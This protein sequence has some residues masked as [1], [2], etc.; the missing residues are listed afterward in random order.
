LIIQKEKEDLEQDQNKMEDLGLFKKNFDIYLDRYLEKKINNISRFTKDSSALS[1]LN[2]L[3]IISLS[4]GKRIRPYLAYLMYKT[5]SKKPNEKIL[6]FLV[7]LEI[8][9]IFC[10]IHDDVMDKSDLR[11]G[12]LTAQKYVFDALKK[13]N[14]IGDLKHVGNSQAIL[15]G[16]IMLAWSQEIINSNQYFPQKIISKINEFFYDMVD[17]VSVG[18]MIDVDI[19]TRKETSKQLID[20][21]TKLKTA[22]YSFTKPLLIGAVLS[23]EI[24]KDIETF[25]KEFGLTMGMAFQTQDDLLDIISTDKKLG[26]TASQD[27]SQNQ[28]TYFT[29]FPSI[30]YGKK[31]IKDN[32]IKARRLIK[33]LKIDI[34]DK[35][36]FLKL[37]GV[38]E[39]RTS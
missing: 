38:I 26:K 23:G 31:I 13:E 28:H 8:F 14:R 22:G 32:F 1:Y 25:C 20:E 19:V 6:E 18:Q 5:L 7:F 17:E 11:H 37:I 29:Y 15:L 3:K 35:Q 34:L 33:E 24:S 36:E 9:H 16:D 21:K 4:G 39:K 12:A 27:K 2:Y 30:E 10:L